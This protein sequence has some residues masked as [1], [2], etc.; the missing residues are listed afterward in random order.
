MKIFCGLTLSLL[1]A[2]SA[3]AQTVQT[4]PTAPSPPPRALIEL[5]TSSESTVKGA[6]FSAEA[7]SESIQTLADGN[8]IIRKSTSKLYRNSQGQFRREGGIGLP[9]AGLGAFVGSGQNSVVTV[10]D[11]VGGNRFWFDA[12]SK[13]ARVYTT[14]GVS[15]GLSGKAPIVIEGNSNAEKIQAEL[16][17]RGMAGVRVVQA[18]RAAAASA[19]TAVIAASPLNSKYETKRESLGIQ[20]FEGVDAEGTRTT[21]IIPADAIG[22]ERPIEIVEERWYSKDLHMVVYSKHSDP[23]FGEQTYRLT[24]INRSEPDPSLFEVPD[25]YRILNTPRGTTVYRPSSRVERISP[26]QTK[27]RVTRTIPVKNATSTAARP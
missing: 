2:A 15:V 21:T 8:R 20:N 5:S 14:P 11:P 24:N 4:P 17:A 19:A 7:V 9:G 27:T 26:T 16:N 25:G 13:T 22:N 3:Q 18:E 23:R 10:L 12:D 6:P 1:A